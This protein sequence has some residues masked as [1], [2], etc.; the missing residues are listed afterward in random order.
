[1]YMIH[2]GKRCPLETCISVWSFDKILSGADTIM[3]DDFLQLEFNSA[4]MLLQSFC[5]LLTYIMMTILCITITSWNT[6]M[7]PHA[8]SSPSNDQGKLVQFVCITTQQCGI[9]VFK[10]PLTTLGNTHLPQR[11]LT[12]HRHSSAA[13]RCTLLL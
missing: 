12:Q 11:S 1:M 4:I 10:Y 9:N 3:G 8:I 2:Y 13:E 7:I 6:S 5:G